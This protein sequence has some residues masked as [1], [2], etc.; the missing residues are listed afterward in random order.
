VAPVA[1]IAPA[2][3]PNGADLTLS[4]DVEPRKPRLAW[5]GMDRR[6]RVV[7]VPTQV[8]E[9]VRPG[10]AIDRRDSLGNTEGRAAAERSDGSGLPPNGLLWPTDSL[11]AVEP[12]LDDRD[13][14][15]RD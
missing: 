11:A 12:L 4:I 13:A 2:T 10:R 6:E 5:Q 9:V 1:T 15:T 3:A 14:G 8:V 7:S